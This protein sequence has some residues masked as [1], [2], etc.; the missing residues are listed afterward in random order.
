MKRPM[1]RVLLDD[2]GVA[3]FEPNIIVRFLL[4]AGPWDLNDLASMSFRRA[5]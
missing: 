1:Q 4:D 5:D 2:D 3:R